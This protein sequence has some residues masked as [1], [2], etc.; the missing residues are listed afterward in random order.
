MFSLNK[1]NVLS[2]LQ[3]FFFIFCNT[4]V[5]PPTLQ[6]AFHLSN[7]TT[8]TITQY[9]FLATSLACLIQAIFGHKR[10]IMEGP[11]GLWWGTI[12]SV[13]FAESAQGTPLEVIG[14]SFAVGIAISG[15]ITVIIGLSGAGKYLALLFSP[16]VMAVFMLLL[17]ANLITIFL[18]GMLGLPFSATT[19]VVHINFDTFLLALLIMVLIIGIIVLFPRHI[20]KYAVL[21][22]SI[23]G[24][25]LFAMIFR[26]DSV[27]TNGIEWQLFPLGKVE[28]INYGIVATCIIAS[29]LNTSN[30]FGAIKGTDLFHP[31]SP[32][33]PAMYRRS[34]ISS[35]AL[36]FACS[37]L[38]IVPFAPFV[39]SIGLI[40]QT[41]DFSK[42]P[43]II[44]SLLF[45]VISF[46]PVF[47]GFFSTFPLVISSTV[48]MVTY[49][50]LL[51]SSL[52]F[53]RILDL[54]PRNIYRLALP[55]FIGIFLMSVP[56]TYMQDIPLMIR[57]IITNGLLM[58]IIISIIL[59]NIFKWDA[60][61]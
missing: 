20:N 7:A 21:I 35:G 58:G 10:S 28:T 26:S 12:L 30:T 11:A 8:Y 15:I 42:K 49:L 56:P 47:S 38:G 13:A 27:G 5:I 6:S 52:L 39:S 60:I 57:P 46:V 53:I 25:F 37:P 9:A 33:T 19:D 50:P 3:W 44:G 4:V 14:G 41:N 51:W 55:I 18:K 59:E 34:F 22:G 54:N 29:L 23:L 45:F 32:A 48:M 43:F 40:T 31:D 16:G 2:G 1:D 24:W 61:K 36:T 17:G